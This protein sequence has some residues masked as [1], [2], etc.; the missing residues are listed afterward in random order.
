[1]AIK[2]PAGTT[3]KAAHD[4]ELY[5]GDKVQVGITS[6]VRINGDDN[7]FRMEVAST[8]REGETGTQ[9]MKRARGFLAEQFKGFVPETAE[10]IMGLGD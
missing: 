8:V 9:A 2:L 7:W 4:Y 3:Q 6:V 10:L 1:M 5:E